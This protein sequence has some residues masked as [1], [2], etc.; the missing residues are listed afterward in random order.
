M[1]IVGLTAGVSP[2]NDFQDSSAALG[3]RSTC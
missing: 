3:R 2:N 1:Q